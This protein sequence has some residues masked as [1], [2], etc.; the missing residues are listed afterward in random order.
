MRKGHLFLSA[1]TLFLFSACTTPEHVDLEPQPIFGT[2]DDG[3]TGESVTSEP[4]DVPETTSPSKSPPTAIPPSTVPPTRPPAPASLPPSTQR[5]PS[6]AANTP[7]KE[8]VPQ[9]TVTATTYARDSRAG[10]QIGQVSPGTHV[11]VRSSDGVWAYGYVAAIEGKG[12]G[13]AW[14]LHEKMRRTGEFCGQ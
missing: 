10:N 3:V 13:W 5:A 2:A 8:C 1:V 9:Y 14:M 11:N 12:G 4:M 6:S 7:L